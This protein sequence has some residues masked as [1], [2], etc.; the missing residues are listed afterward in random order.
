MKRAL[1]TQADVSHYKKIIKAELDLKQK[2]VGID[3]KLDYILQKISELKAL[4]SA[5]DGIQL[6]IFAMSAL[7]HCEKFDGL[8]PG[9]IKDLISVAEATLKVF[10]I[11]PKKS[12]L[13]FLYGELSMITSQIY[14][15]EGLFWKATWEQYVA[16]YLSGHQAPGG[17][18]YIDLLFGIKLLRLG[19]GSRA[20]V[21]FKEAEN[22]DGTNGIWNLARINRI[23]T[24]R[25][26]GKLPEALDLIRETKAIE[27]NADLLLELNWESACCSIHDTQNLD[28]MAQMV[29][30]GSSHYLASYVLEFH[31]WALT[32][33]SFHWIQTTPKIRTLMRDEVLG[34]QDQKFY[35]AMAREL[36]KVYDETI[37]LTTRLQNLGTILEKID[38][39]HSV[40]KQLLILAAVSRWLIRNKIKNLSEVILLEYESVCTKMSQGR[41]HDL[42]GILGDSLPA[43]NDSL[44]DP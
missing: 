7:V 36:E 24:L 15:K 37:I 2:E 19:H 35:Y 6:F 12:T 8:N 27:I 43:F 32:V 9:Q 18:S 13:A 30:K 3:G 20:L 29:Q 40:D 21:Y 14:L 4:G 22:Q 11:V 17:K 25:L 23:R 42:L 28:E 39:C 31:L 41:T 33:P 26:T 44:P 1:W 10:H 38:Q 34:I 5:K 16:I